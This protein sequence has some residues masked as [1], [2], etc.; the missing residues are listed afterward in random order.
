MDWIG[1]FGYMSCLK[2]VDGAHVAY[3]LS[4]LV[5]PSSLASLPDFKETLDSLYVFKR[6]QI[7]LKEIIEPAFHRQQAP[8]TLIHY[9]SGYA[10]EQRITPTTLFTPVQKQKDNQN[11]TATKDINDDEDM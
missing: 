4:S 2:P 10:N 5:L 7:K 11:A 6:R 3:H 8:S 1:D 9:R